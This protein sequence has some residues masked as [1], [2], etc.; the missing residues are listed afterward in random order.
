MITHKYRKIL[1]LIFLCIAVYLINVEAKEKL[2]CDYPIHR[3]DVENDNAKK[4]K[5]AFT[6]D[7]AYENKYVGNILDVL[8]KY[9]IK[10]TFFVTYE[11]AHKNPQWIKEIAKRGHELG[12]H[13]NT[14][15]NFRKISIN[16]MVDEVMKCHNEVYY[17]TGQFMRLFRYPYGS[18]NHTSMQVLSNLGYYSIQWNIDTIDWKNDG[19]NKIK[20]RIN[21][22]K[23]K[24]V[25]GS[26]V[27][28]HTSGKYTADATEYLVQLCKEKGYDIVKVSDLIYPY[29]TVLDD[30]V[31]VK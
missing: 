25:G 3:V 2:M 13:S 31:Q 11:W 12:N 19:L 14:H 26:I 18:Y 6:Y 15:P 29:G 30:G 1:F 23:N 22:R 21:A 7:S 16:K 28:M 17:L 10:S 8:D 9:K 27:L 24:F 20:G 5:V 4:N